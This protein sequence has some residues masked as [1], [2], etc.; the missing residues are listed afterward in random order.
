MRSPSP[1]Q[2]GGGAGIALHVPLESSIHAFREQWEL[3][4]Q[5]HACS[6]SWVVEC[7]ESWKRD[8]DGKMRKEE[9]GEVHEEIF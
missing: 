9:F 6:S 5:R 1:T 4:I 2:G 8:E 7:F 3:H